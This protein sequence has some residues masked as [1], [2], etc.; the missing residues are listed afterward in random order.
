L[1]RGLNEGRGKNYPA[2]RSRDEKESKRRR[3]GRSTAARRKR[4]G[5]REV[6]RTY[7]LL[8]GIPRQ[9]QKKFG[10]LARRG[11]FLERDPLVDRFF[12]EARGIGLSRSGRRARS[13]FGH[14]QFRRGLTRGAWGIGRGKRTSGQNRGCGKVSRSLS[15]FCMFDLGENVVR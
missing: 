12:E 2:P 11:L 5:A 13:S 10:R 15:T 3:S 4:E 8:V 7:S 9:R 6:F 14:G 1:W